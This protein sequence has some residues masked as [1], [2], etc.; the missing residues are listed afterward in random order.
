LGFRLFSAWPTSDLGPIGLSDARPSVCM[1]RAAGGP[2]PTPPRELT[3]QRVKSPTDLASFEAVLATSFDHD[4][5]AIFP[6]Q[7]LADRSIRLWLGTVD[8]RPVS[9]RSHG[10]ALGWRGA[11]RLA[12]PTRPHR[13]PRAMQTARSAGHWVELSWR[14]TIGLETPSSIRDATA[15]PSDERIVGR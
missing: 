10:R 4:A 14:A 12:R 6:A 7:V 13:Q 3:I 11:P 2:V 8:G 9:C 15:A 5:K 1:V